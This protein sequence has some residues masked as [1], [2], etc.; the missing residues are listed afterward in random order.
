MLRL[1]KES[2]G[3]QSDTAVTEVAGDENDGL[4]TVTDATVVV[5]SCSK[6]FILD[7]TGVEVS[8]DAH[9][10]G[11]PSTVAGMLAQTAA[12]LILRLVTRSAMRLPG[13]SGFIS[14]WFEDLSIAEDISPNSVLHSQRSV[15]EGI[16]GCKTPSSETSIICLDEFGTTEVVQGN[17]VGCIWTE[18]PFLKTLTRDIFLKCVRVEMKRNL[19]AFEDEGRDVAS[20]KVGELDSITGFVSAGDLTLEAEP[21]FL[22]Q[23]VRLVLSDSLINI[24]WISLMPMLERG[25]RSDVRNKQQIAAYS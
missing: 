19:R 10:A 1:A 20:S 23:K 16:T 9:E 6:E 14:S 24:L 15:G 5:S 22:R 17:T 12:V 8:L 11:S 4:S 3:P 7:L 21:P 18:G 13:G 2:R 25:P